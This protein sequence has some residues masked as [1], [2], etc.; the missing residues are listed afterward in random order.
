MTLEQL[1]E[2]NSG[3][4]P[5]KLENNYILLSDLGDELYLVRKDEFTGDKNK[6]ESWMKVSSANEEEFIIHFPKTYGLFHEGHFYI[7]SE[8]YYG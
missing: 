7:R 2:E 8:D 6:Y 1:R 5:E 4:N 3:Y